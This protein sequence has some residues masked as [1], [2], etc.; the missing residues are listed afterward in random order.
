V[1][2]AIYGECEKVGSGAWCYGDAIKN[3]GH[4]FSFF[5]PTLLLKPWMDGVV[6]RLWRHVGYPELP[7]LFLLRHQRELESFLERERPE[8]MFVL[9]GLWV[10]VETL[11]VAAQIG[12]KVVLI[13]HDDFFSR[14][15]F[16]WSLLQRAALKEYAKIYSTRRVNV[17]ELKALGLAAEFFPFAYHP[18]IHF[19]PTDLNGSRGSLGPALF[20][21][22]YERERANLLEEVAAEGVKLAVY[23]EQ[24]N[25][26]RARS[27]LRKFITDGFLSGENLRR[28]IFGA[29]CCLG[30]LRKENRDEYTQ[31]SIE[32]PACGGVLLAERT[33]EH[34]RM[35]KEGVDADFFDAD[36]PIELA[37][38]IQLLTREKERA[39]SIRRS[40]MA[41]VARL[42]YTYDDRVR[43]ILDEFEP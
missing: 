18:K 17:E 23:G 16:N 29:S 4:Q 11:R 24:W 40:G 3:A 21:G 15:R 20:V 32:I 36:S 6:W 2:I 10:K 28:A 8:L 38:K 42:K 31:R 9:K 37:D 35:F 26:L 19:P 43:Q 7:P 41:A 34:L 12:C 25:K 30:F 27:P 39:F 22:T 1:R 13:N 14:N 5:S 33:Q